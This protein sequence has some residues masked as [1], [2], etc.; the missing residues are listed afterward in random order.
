M[1]KVIQ[2]KNNQE[3]TE[4]CCEFCDL[5]LEFMEYAKETES[6]EELFN[7]LREFANEVSVL[8]L[9]QYLTQELS[10]KVELLDTLTYGYCEDDCDECEDFC[11]CEDD[12][13]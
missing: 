9:R 4:S 6:E 13:D 5:T 8:S 11:D 1:S 10:N 7:V 3:E 2:F 12:E